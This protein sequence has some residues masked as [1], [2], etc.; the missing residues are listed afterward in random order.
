MIYLGGGGKS[1][2][3]PLG[4]RTPPPPVFPWKGKEG[5]KKNNHRIYFSGV[6][7]LKE[8]ISK[9]K[10][11]PFEGISPLIGYQIYLSVPS[12]E[13]QKPHPPSPPSLS[14]P[15]GNPSPTPPPPP[16]PAASTPPHHMWEEIPRRD[17]PMKRLSGGTVSVKQKG[18]GKRRREK[19]KIF[20]FFLHW[21]GEGPLNIPLLGNPPP[22]KKGPL[23]SFHD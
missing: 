6:E 1:H 2:L 12:I 10:E 22:P 7:N 13:K 20:I 18:G 16:Q 19:G 11:R 4:E 21:G 17:R 8:T 9:K 3:C 23:L 5:R 14:P 15:R